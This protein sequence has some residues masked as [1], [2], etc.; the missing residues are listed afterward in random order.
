MGGISVLAPDFVSLFLVGRNALLI[1]VISHLGTKHIDGALLPVS[2]RI[3]QDRAGML[4][5][6]RGTSRQQQYEK[7]QD[8]YTIHS[9]PW[10][11]LIEVY[12]NGCRALFTATESKKFP[13]DP[14]RLI[15]TP[16]RIALL[17]KRAD[18]LLVFLIGLFIASH[19]DLATL[20]FSSRPVH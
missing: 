15:L 4:G 7:E 9:I 19:T 16:N 12:I 20:C 1:P 13:I 2:F 18:T 8:D 3:H 11:E 10:Q 14:G 5:D 17:L 6:N